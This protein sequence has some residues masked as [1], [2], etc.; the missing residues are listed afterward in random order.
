MSRYR[1]GYGRQWDPYVPVAQRKRLAQQKA[2]RRLKKGQSL[3][4]IRITARK[5]ATTFWGTAWCDNLEHYSDFANRLPRGRT[6]ARNG[7]IVDLQIKTGKITALV[8]GSTPYDVKITITKLGDKRWKQLQKDCAESIHSL[9]DLM[10]GKLPD[11]VL[12]RL[13]DSKKGLFPAP[14]EIR[15]SC[16]CP[17]G[18]S[19]CKH[20]AAVL[21]GVGHRLDSEPDL[22]FRLRGVNQQD[23]ISEALTTQ[24][25]DA[26]L[27][28]DHESALDS[29]DLES[30]FGI[31]L[32]TSGQASKPPARK[33]ATNKK[34]TKKRSPK[35]TKKAT[36]KRSPKSTKKTAQTKATKKKIASKTTTRAKVSTAPKSGKVAAK[37]PAQRGPK[38]KKKKA[39]KKT[40]RKVATV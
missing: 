7:S 25:V 22:F 2:K 6:Y 5:I 15:L 29:G 3:A 1:Y 38:T 24:S 37:E 18:A 39:A 20:L 9:I 34:P 26:A 27:G 21:Y 40:R 23:L 31:D 13:T 36:K 28:L 4:P 30:I 11:Q 8:A 19:L 32:V 10:R 33:K 14:S 12:R 17:D 35:L 16:S